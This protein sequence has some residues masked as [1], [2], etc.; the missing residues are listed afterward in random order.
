MTSYQR[1]YRAAVLAIA[2]D[3]GSRADLAVERCA[4][5][6]LDALRS[7]ADHAQGLR[8]AAQ[9]ASL[10]ANEPPHDPEAVVKDP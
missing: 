5:T 10:Y 1:G 8:H 2:A 4:V 9:L 7:V 6:G 3:L